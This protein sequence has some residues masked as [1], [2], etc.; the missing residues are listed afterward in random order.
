VHHHTSDSLS[1]PVMNMECRACF[2]KMMNCLPHFVCFCCWLQD[3]PQ[4]IKESFY[5]SDWEHS[6]FFTYL[7]EA[8]RA[9]Y[10]PAPSPRVRTMAHMWVDGQ[11]TGMILPASIDTTSSGSALVEFL[12][13]SIQHH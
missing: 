11:H 3:W 5:V 13:E 2:T 10:W 1:A 8:M 12:G 4:K 6:S 7:P 9:E